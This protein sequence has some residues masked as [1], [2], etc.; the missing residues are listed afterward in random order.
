M[1]LP[2]SIVDSVALQLKASSVLLA[3]LVGGVYS[4]RQAFSGQSTPRDVA[5]YL[6]PFVVV[7]NSGEG[8]LVGQM[9]T[10]YYRYFFNLYFY[11]D[12]ERDYTTMIQAAQL[13]RNVLH[14]RNLPN[15]S[16]AT[17]SASVCINQP[18]TMQGQEMAFAANRLLVP[19]SITIQ[20]R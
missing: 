12:L 14:L 17:T 3:L 4:G 10:D 8:A 7:A 20:R 18:G 13:A 11:D 15:A 2:V 6:A 5:G 9:Q 1:S 19:Y 16:E